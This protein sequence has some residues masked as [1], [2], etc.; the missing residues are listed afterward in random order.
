M[1]KNLVK[2]TKQRETLWHNLRNLLK[3]KRKF[4]GVIIEIFCT[5]T[6]FKILILKIIITTMYFKG[7]TL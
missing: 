3:N 7:V 5:R 1:K 2:H 4:A 6:S